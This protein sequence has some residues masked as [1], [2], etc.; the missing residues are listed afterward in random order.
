METL[1]EKGQD[2]PLVENERWLKRIFYA[3]VTIAVLAL[4]NV[5]QG[6]FD[7]RHQTDQEAFNDLTIA[8]EKAAMDPLDPAITPDQ[9]NGLRQRFG[10][11]KLTDTQIIRLADR[12][13]VKEK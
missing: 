6:A 13:G 11:E 8:W 3:A 1:T 12:L 2:V 7:H 5:V 4:A 10:L 9:I